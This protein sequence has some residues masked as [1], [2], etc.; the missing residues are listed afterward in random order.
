MAVL[1]TRPDQ[2]GEQLADM[3]NKAGIAA[4]HLPLFTIEPGAELNDLPNKINQLKSGDYVFAVSRHAVDYAAAT[5]KHTGFH[6]RSDLHYFTVGQRTAA[7]FAGQSEQCVAYPLVQE[8]SEGLLALPA[9]SDL[10]GKS[11]LI[12]RGNGGREFFAEQ[13]GIR[14]AEVSGVA[15]YQRMPI[16]YHH[17]EQTSLCK[18]AGVNTIVATSMDILTA[19]MDFVPENEHN[20]LTGCRLITVSRRIAQFAEQAGWKNVIISPRADNQTLLH[21]LLQSN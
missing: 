20:W 1:I 10:S 16:A 21:T 11:I 2:R 15:C 19:L 9:M 14:G 12:L 5:L 6:W 4:I 13:A 3:L 8:S 17:A 7:Y 18:R